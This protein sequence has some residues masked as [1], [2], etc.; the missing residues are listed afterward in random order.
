MIWVNPEHNTRP[1]NAVLDEGPSWTD[2]DTFHG[3][4]PSD[5]GTLLLKRCLPSAPAIKPPYLLNALSLGHL[6]STWRYPRKASGTTEVYFVTLALADAR[7]LLS[8][9]VCIASG[10]KLQPNMMASSAFVQLVLCSL[11]F[12]GRKAD[13]GHKLPINNVVPA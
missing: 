6:F 11:C 12:R 4:R 1:G 10:V 2:H 3:V 7:Q 8:G 13:S 9:M 5:N